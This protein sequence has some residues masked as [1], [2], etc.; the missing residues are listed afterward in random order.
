MPL[1]NLEFLGERDININ[2]YSNEWKNSNSGKQNYVI[3]FMLK[4]SVYV[5][6]I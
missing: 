6:I 2:H 3:K 5:Y 1:Q 4:Y